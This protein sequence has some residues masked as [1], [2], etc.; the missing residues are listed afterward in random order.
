[1]YGQY[2]TFVLLEFHNETKSHE[3]FGSKGIMGRFKYT[4]DEKRGFEN[5]VTVLRFRELKLSINL[6]LPISIV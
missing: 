5:T 2:D 4:L 6:F 3:L 1:M